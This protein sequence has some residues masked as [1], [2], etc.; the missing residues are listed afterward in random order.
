MA[1]T[2]ALF[3]GLSGLS[4]HA[5]RLEVIG[6]NIANVSTTAY[7]SNRML[8]AS[9]INRN[10]SL[11]TA[12]SGASGGTNP[13]QVGLGVTIAGTQRDFSNGAIS[14]TGISRDMAIEGGGFFVVDRAGQQLY[15]RAGAF[16]FNAQNELVTISGDRLMGFGVDEDFNITEGQIEPLTVPL[17]TMTLAEA[18][19]NVSF[20][21]NLDADGDIGT[22]GSNL[23]FA[24]LTSGGPG[25]FATGA[26][27][28]TAIDGGGFAAGDVITVS[29]ATRGGK[30]QPD[31]TFELTT[32]TE[33][34]DD[35]L[36]F[37]QEALGVVP[38][39]GA[40]PGDPGGGIEPGS[41]SITNGVIDFVGNFGEQN[42][43]DLSAGNI[44]VEDTTGTAKAHPFD[45]TKTQTADG[46]SVRTS[47]IVYDSL[48]TAM[49]VDITFVLA[50]KDNSG[51]YWRPFLHSADDTDLALHL[52]SG[53]RS[54]VGG[55]DDSIPMVQFDN[56]GQL[57]GPETVSVQL[58]RMDTGA[59][60]PLTFNLD[61]SGQAG[62]ITAYSDAGGSST[63]ASVFQD[64]SPLG[65]LTNFAVGA[66]GI[67]TGGFTNGL[68]RVIGQV[69]L[70]GFT[71]PEGLVD[72]GDNLF[73]VGPN[74]GSPVISQPL[75][76]SNGRII[77]GALELSNV[78]LS[79][80]FIEMIL[81]ST[82]YSASSRVISTADQLLQQLLLL[83]Q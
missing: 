49:S 61:F 71:N 16:Q 68:T 11:G 42:D 80:E 44:S 39:G 12:P 73:N 83:A 3:T 74:S 66:D 18:T 28:L 15:T 78:D 10:F 62:M 5:R 45:I 52:E 40:S 69:A 34:I 32:G 70:A 59:S 21:G 6:N 9:G 46:E 57:V 14:P 43:L 17:G 60:D 25:V 58:D 64:G 81:T 23:Q 4:T 30:L 19:E 50:F 35:F 36:A 31:A 75:E 48:G 47:Y 24:E 20:T 77:G 13:G 82:G 8:F 7:K 56:F 67:V 2:G 37:L 63:I 54:I 29:G 33:T 26:T 27:L 55:Y 72:V 51:T 76:F 38:N 53:D 65:T 41:F 1:S 22:Q 79:K